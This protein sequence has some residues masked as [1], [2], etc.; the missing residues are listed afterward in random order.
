MANGAITA[1]FEFFPPKSE[2]MERQ[3]WASVERLLPLSPDFVSVTYGA[4][5]STRERTH[6]TVSRL[7]SE[8]PLRPAA[9]LTCVKATREQIDE[10][11]RDYWN[12]GVRHI[13]ALRGDPPEGIGE[14]YQPFPGGYEN[15]ADLAAGIRSI[16]D[17]EISVGVY[18]EKHPESP[19][20]DADIEHLKRKVDAGATRGISQFFFEA[21]HFLRYRDR[22][23]KAGIDIDLTPGIM[24]VTNFKGVRRMAEGCGTNIPN[25]LAEKYDGLDR[26]AETRKLI[27]A[28]VAAD[29]CFAL[30]R[31]GVQHFH[32][33]TLNRADLTFAVCH[34]LGMRPEPV[35]AQPALAA[36]A[37]N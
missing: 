12:E 8:T 17:F 9:H 26:D 1:S 2:D 3:L 32:F 24:P 16:G 33:Y 7:I 11:I 15:A 22:V 35:A 19:S 31:E 29:L 25:W 10:V 30:Q 14:R 28:T 6:R 37:A 23:E 21:E 27:A 4:G 13:V 20:F 36:G 18:P 34:L 5:G